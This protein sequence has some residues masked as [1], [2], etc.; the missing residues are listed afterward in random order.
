M[1]LLK[2]YIPVAFVVSPTEPS[3]KS[4]EKFIDDFFSRECSFEDIV[5]KIVEEISMPVRN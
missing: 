4:Y 1:S 5:K 2:D 3:N